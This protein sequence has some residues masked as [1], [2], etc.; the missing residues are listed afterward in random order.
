MFRLC[1]DYRLERDTAPLAYSLLWVLHELTSIIPL[2]AVFFG[3]RAVGAGDKVAELVP[4]EWIQEGEQWAGRVGRRY[5]LF[6]FE[7]TDKGKDD[8]PAEVAIVGDVANAVLAPNQDARVAAISVATKLD[9]SDVQ[10]LDVTSPYVM[11]D[12][13]YAIHKFQGQTFHSFLYSMHLFVPG[14][15]C[16]LNLFIHQSAELNP[17]SWVLDPLITYAPHQRLSNLVYLY[18]QLS[19]PL[20]PISTLVDRICLL[21]FF[22]THSCILSS[23][24]P[25][26]F[27]RSRA[28][29][30]DS[31][32]LDSPPFLLSQSQPIKHPR[33]HTSF[34]LLAISQSPSFGY[35]RVSA[36]FWCD[37]L[38][39]NVAH[40]S[41]HD[42]A[43]FPATTLQVL[44]ASVLLLIAELLA[45]PLLK[46]TFRP[47][48]Y[49]ESHRSLLAAS[50]TCHALR[51]ACFPLAIRI[52]R[53][54]EP[55]PL[56]RADLGESAR[57]L[58]RRIEWVL[59]RDDLWPYIRMIDIEMFARGSSSLGTKLAT[60]ISSLA[61]LDSF[62][63][64]LPT[65]RTLCV[66]AHSAWMVPL[67]PGATELVVWCWPKPG[68]CEDEERT[69][70]WKMVFGSLGAQAPRVAELEIGGLS[71]WDVN[72]MFPSLANLL[73]NIQVLRI[74]H[75]SE[76][77][78]SIP[79]PSSHFPHAHR[80]SALSNNSNCAAPAYSPP[81]NP[82]PLGRLPV[83]S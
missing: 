60:F 76:P 4:A 10:A 37:V 2:A 52:F 82:F 45:P 51:R 62:A 25:A 40:S 46:H 42:A 59:T 74:L 35:P 14:R 50:L 29:Y 19:C 17:S 24:P 28:G 36:L 32:G 16:H 38:W 81:L 78:G 71:I 41:R 22:V 55:R 27:G 15:I 34:R 5:G 53:N 73:G 18:Y 63:L 48:G 72:E 57:E 12:I 49:R 61:H 47:P 39:Y 11:I 64:R 30:S 8:P 56:N 9:G 58:E 75:R 83:G 70:G 6:G 69:D 7:K 67:F 1:R 3:A 77:Y 80:R 20:G 65:F 26:A 43:G 23:P 31:T 44:P 13:S 33:T 66:D 21:Y 54:H 68:T 79:I